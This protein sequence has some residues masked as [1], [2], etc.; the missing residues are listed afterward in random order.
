MDTSNDAT[1]C[2]SSGGRR[3][4][5]RRAGSTG[6]ALARPDSPP[7]APPCGRRLV[8]PARQD[9]ATAAP[10]VTEP[11]GQACA[12]VTPP[13]APFVG[14]HSLSSP[15]LPGTLRPS[16]ASGR[17]GPSPARPRP[18]GPRRSRSRQRLRWPTARRASGLPSRPPPA[19]RPADRT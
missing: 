13:R 18:G 15:G 4:P 16:P 6:A 3:S 14:R 9:S 1:T 5:G 7:A 19:R 17:S 12:G 8:S 2:D 10:V 11:V